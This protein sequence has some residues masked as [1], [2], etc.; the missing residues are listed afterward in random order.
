LYKHRPNCRG[1]VVSRDNGGGRAYP[2][3]RISKYRISR[4]LHDAS[5]GWRDSCIRYLAPLVDSG[6]AHGKEFR[7]M[8]SPVRA[9]AG[10]VRAVADAR[11]GVRLVQPMPLPAS[12]ALI[13]QLV[14]SVEDGSRGRRSANQGTTFHVGSLVPGRASGEW[15]CVLLGTCPG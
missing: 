5:G 6:F 10:A 15:G 2:E 8:H 13:S 14:P 11:G 7:A 9:V 12:R 4:V 1:G 3:V